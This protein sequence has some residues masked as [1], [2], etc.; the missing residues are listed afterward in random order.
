MTLKL[1]IKQIINEKSQ[2]KKKKKRV[3]NSQIEK[4]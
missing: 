2:K 1:F 4:N 3:N